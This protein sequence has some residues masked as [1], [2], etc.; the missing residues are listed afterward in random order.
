MANAQPNPRESSCANNFFKEHVQTIGPRRCKQMANVRLFVLT[1]S[2]DKSTYIARWPLQ[3]PDALPKF[4][5]WTQSTLPKVSFGFQESHCS[6]LVDCLRLEDCYFLD[7]QTA[8]HLSS[9]AWKTYEL[10]S[11][12]CSASGDLRETAPYR[13]LVHKTCSSTSLGHFGPFLK[14]T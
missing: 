10:M 8:H 11:Y 6:I 5:K 14:H 13:S 1:K 12:T 9:H 4:P 3:S 2:P 7:H